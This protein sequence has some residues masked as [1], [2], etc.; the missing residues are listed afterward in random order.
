MLLNKE[1]VVTI[2]T[3]K[4]CP[5]CDAAKSLLSWAEIKFTEI[6]VKNN[7]NYTFKDKVLFEDEHLPKIFIDN[8][9]IGS[10]QQLVELIAEGKL[11]Q[12]VEHE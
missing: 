8:E 6:D 11:L 4:D 5:Y 10:Y 12:V 9:L 7:T 2:Y 3:K 1:I